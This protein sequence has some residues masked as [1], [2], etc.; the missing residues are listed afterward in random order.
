MV[1]KQDMIRFSPPFLLM[2]SCAAPGSERASAPAFPP[3][4][5]RMPPKGRDGVPLRCIGHDGRGGPVFADPEAPPEPPR[6]TVEMCQRKTKAELIE[7]LIL[8]DTAVRNQRRVIEEQ[9]EA[10][11]RLLEVAVEADRAAAST[12]DLANV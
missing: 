6:V 3:L 5:A 1:Q 10:I 7:M 11:G 4:D 2:H 9:T 8:A 12:E